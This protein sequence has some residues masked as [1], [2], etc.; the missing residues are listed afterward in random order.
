MQEGVQ[1]P[2]TLGVPPPP[3]VLGMMQLFGQVPLQPS[4]PP[5]LPAQAI[6][7]LPHTLGVP[8]PPQVSGMMQLFGQ[9]P[10]QPSG[11]PHLPVQAFEHPHTLGVPP[12]PQ[13]LGMMQL[14]GQVPLQPSGPP[15]LPA[16]TFE[17]PHML[18][19][20]PPPQVSGGVQCPSRHRPPQ[21]SSAPQALPAQSAA[22]GLLQEPSHRTV[23]PHIPQGA[24]TLA[25][26]QSHRASG[27]SPL[28]ILPALHVVVLICTQLVVGSAAQSAR[29]PSGVQ[30]WPVRPAHSGGGGGHEQLAVGNEPVQGFSGGQLIRRTSDKQPRSSFMQTTIEVPDWHAAPCPCSQP[31]GGALHW[32]DAVGALPWQ[33]FPAGQASPGLQ[34]RHPPSGKQ[35]ISSPVGPH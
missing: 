24:P 9:V 4:G 12:P 34:P 27:N 16:Q 30:K 2:H 23:P 7:Q 6:E 31:A 8:P 14:F 10:L 35:V 1:V 17:H 29:W 19:V 5:H 20:P 33:D 3:Q 26:T 25:A 28:Q 18:G 15:H 11:P 32:Q 13:V 21:P 22:M